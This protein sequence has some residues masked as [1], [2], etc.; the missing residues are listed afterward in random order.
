MSRED[1]DRMIKRLNCFVAERKSPTTPIMPI[2]LLD[3]DVTF[4]LHWV[5]L[6]PSMAQSVGRVLR[7]DDFPKCPS[8]RVECCHGH[9]DNGCEMRDVWAVSES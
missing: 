6:S 8:C 3:D 5:S 2:K 1:V 4:K 7:V 9:P